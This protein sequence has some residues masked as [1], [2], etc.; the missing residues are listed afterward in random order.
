MDM[1][2]SELEIEQQAVVKNELESFADADLQ[3]ISGFPN[4]A[5]QN[6]TSPL[7]LNT[8]W[9]QFF[10]ELATGSAQGRS[11]PVTQ[12]M[13]I[14][15]NAVAGN[16]FGND[17]E[18]SATPT[19]EGVDMHFQSI[20]RRSLARGEALALPTAVAK[21]PFEQIVE[22][23]VPDTR[24]ETGAIIRRDRSGNRDDEDVAWDAICFKNPF[25]FAMTTAPAL[26]TNQ[27]A[28]AGQQVST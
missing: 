20:G 21:A 18:L 8:S 3:L 15:N 14:S 13:V 9:P 27:R 25:P 22:W 6:V 16:G 28:F 11:S 4:I 1:Q 17:D 7:S 2:S 26:I 19:G 5:M 10:R 23:I 12:Q 24:T